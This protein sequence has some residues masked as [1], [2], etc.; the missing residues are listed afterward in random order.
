MDV[1]RAFGG[2]KAVNGAS[3]SVAAGR[4]TG[5]IG[6]NGAGKSTICG[7][8]AGALQPDSGHILLDGRDIGG[9]PAYQVSRAGV[10]RTF[11][12]SSEFAKLTVLEN[13]VAAAPSQRGESLLGAMLGRR[14]WGPQ[15]RANVHR[16]R[17]LL[18]RVGLIGKQDE[19]AGN[20]SGGQKRLVEITRALMAEPRMLLLDEPMAGIHPNLAHSVADYLARLAEGGLTMLMIEHELGLVERLCDTVI[21]MAQGRVISE[22]RMDEVR[23]HQAV[24]DAYLVG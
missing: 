22:G 14:Y 3:F 13:L 1:H 11:Q 17:E 12:L 23:Q 15:E 2:V 6:P 20:L 7:L 24:L 16:A 19:Y 9:R 5:L 10:V 18:D 4:I 21:V 8:I